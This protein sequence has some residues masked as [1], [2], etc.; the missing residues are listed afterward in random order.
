[1][2]L[3]FWVIQPYQSLSGAGLLLLG[4]LHLLRLL[5]WHF[6]NTFSEPLVTVLHLGYLWLALAFAL[7]GISILA[8]GLLAPS[9]ALHALTTGAVGTMTLAVMTRATRGH[10]G[11]PLQA[12]AL[13]VVIYL[14]VT[15]AA[16]LR[17][18]I[19]LWPFDYMTSIGLS[20][21]LWCLAFILFLLSYGPML[22]RA[23]Q[24]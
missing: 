19:G 7:M 5:R 12:D 21:L 17:T 1:V 22:L 10:T 8:P 13:S 9:A 3:L 23:N 2:V 15:A 4:G 18:G 14:S 20:T 16:V 24:S 6:W 11:R